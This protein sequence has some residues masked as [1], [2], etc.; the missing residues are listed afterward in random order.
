M[1]EYQDALDRSEMLRSED[2]IR[3]AFGLLGKD[4]TACHTALMMAMHD[5]YPLS[6]GIFIAL[7]HIKKDRDRLRDVVLE[8]TKTHITPI[9]ILQPDNR[10]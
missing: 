2:K 8:Y 9:K 5:N 1:S 4:D 3:I 6:A 10:E 7:E